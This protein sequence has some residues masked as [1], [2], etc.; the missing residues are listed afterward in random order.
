[1][2][3]GVVWWIGGMFASSRLFARGDLVG[4]LG[5][6]GELVCSLGSVVTAVAC[7]TLMGI[8]VGLWPARN[9]GRLDPIEAW[10]RD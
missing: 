7:A 6:E 9:A 4:W 2:G 10:A 3:A 8:G 1:V 5:K